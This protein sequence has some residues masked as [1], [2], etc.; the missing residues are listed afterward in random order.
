MVPGREWLVGISID[1]G[2]LECGASSTRET[3]AVE[4]ELNLRVF[5]FFT[6]SSSVS[7]DSS[8]VIIVVVRLLIS[9]FIIVIHLTLLAPPC[10][11]CGGAASSGRC[12]T[13]TAPCCAPSGPSPRYYD[14]IPVRVYMHSHRHYADIAARVHHAHPRHVPLQHGHQAE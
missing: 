1:H 7:Q 12:S 6:T 2:A 5:I 14:A 9:C 4:F 8:F 13:C 11:H 10:R 3:S